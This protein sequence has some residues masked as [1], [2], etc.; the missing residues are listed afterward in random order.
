MLYKFKSAA[1]GDLIMLAPHGDELMRVLQREPAA[2]GIIE[3]E[4]MAQA[5][6]LIKA[7]VAQAEAPPDDGSDDHDDNLRQAPKVG[8]RQRLW[9]MVLMLERSLAER[10]PIVWGV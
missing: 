8:L 4:A 5:L 9:P 6:V 7:A 10:V 2:R 1:S 3:V